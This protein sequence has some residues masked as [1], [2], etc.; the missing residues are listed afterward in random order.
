MKYA[1]GIC[2]SIKRI[3][4][5]NTTEGSF[6]GWLC[7]LCGSF[8]SLEEYQKADWKAQAEQERASLKKFGK[9]KL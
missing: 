5:L 6:Q 1:C 2:D 8:T 3:A 7:P 9:V 4:I